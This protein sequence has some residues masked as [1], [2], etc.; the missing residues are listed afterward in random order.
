MLVQRVTDFR[1][2]VMLRLYCFSNLRR[3]RIQ[4]SCLPMA[5]D[6]VEVCENADVFPEDVCDLSP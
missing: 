6:M 3:V 5:S 1:V 2:L 4:D